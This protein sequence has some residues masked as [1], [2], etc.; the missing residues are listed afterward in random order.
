MKKIIEHNFIFYVIDQDP[1]E[2]EELFQERSQYILSNLDKD[3][4]ENLIK[5]SRM[6]S[7]V[8]NYNCNYNCF[9]YET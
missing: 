3:K 8:K 5:K 9:S 4:F 6:M 2:P 1:F 7:N